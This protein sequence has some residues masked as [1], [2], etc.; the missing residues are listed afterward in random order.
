MLFRSPPYEINSFL[1]VRGLICFFYSIFL[2]LFLL[3]CQGIDDKCIGMTRKYNVDWP[4]LQFVYRGFV[5][6]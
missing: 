1:F 5:V 6:D 2:L 3:L 4:S